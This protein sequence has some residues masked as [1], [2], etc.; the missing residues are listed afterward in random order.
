MVSRLLRH[1]ICRTT[2]FQFPTAWVQR[3]VVV[4]VVRVGVTVAVPVVVIVVATIVAVVVHAVADVCTKCV[5]AGL[6]H[7]VCS[8]EALSALDSCGRSYL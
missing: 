4:V 3:A 5:I 7:S 1:G 2:Q 8:S 6:A